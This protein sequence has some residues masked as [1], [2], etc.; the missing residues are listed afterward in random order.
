LWVRAISPVCPE[1]TS[2]SNMA[3]LLSEIT[4]WGRS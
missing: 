2:S 4:L 1:T 3:T